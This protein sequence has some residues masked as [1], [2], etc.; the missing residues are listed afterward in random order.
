MLA[1]SVKTQTLILPLNILNLVESS[2][3][4]AMRSLKKI[5]LQMLPALEDCTDTKSDSIS[6]TKV[7]ELQGNQNC[8]CR[9]SVCYALLAIQL[10]FTFQQAVNQ[11]KNH[12]IFSAHTGLVSL[13]TIIIISP[14][15]ATRCLVYS[16]SH[17]CNAVEATANLV[18]HHL[19]TSTVDWCT[20]VFLVYG[21]KKKDKWKIYNLKKTL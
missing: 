5:A 8:T 1:E 10:V 12:V 20:S 15:S 2:D 3:M 21:F 13:V 18:S 16:S 7:D 9:I 4:P 19:G 6:R 17:S 11:H 14:T